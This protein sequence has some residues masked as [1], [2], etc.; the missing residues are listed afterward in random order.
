MQAKHLQISAILTHSDD[1][2]NRNFENNPGIRGVLESVGLQ[3]LEHTVL[4][5]WETYKVPRWNMTGSIGP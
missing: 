1:I 5:Y 3:E 2:E 4:R